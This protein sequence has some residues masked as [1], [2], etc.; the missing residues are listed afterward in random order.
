MSCLDRLAIITVALPK[1]V[2]TIARPTIIFTVGS[3]PTRVAK[4]G[5]L[6][7][8][9]KVGYRLHKHEDTLDSELQNFAIPTNFKVEVHQPCFVEV[10]VEANNPNR[11]TLAV[12]AKL[13]A[14]AI[15]SFRW[16][17]IISLTSGN[18]PPPGYGI[19]VEGL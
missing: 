16:G 4:G 12:L 1:A 11:Q 19:P 3:A 15:Q 8:R 2:P 14:C 13:N 17:V 9:I 18:A 6:T 7:D 10:E 5:T